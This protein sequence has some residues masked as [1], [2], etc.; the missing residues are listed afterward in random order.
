M[1]GS[2]HCKLTH[3]NIMERSFIFCVQLIVYS[4]IYMVGE[5]VRFLFTSCEESQLVNKNRTSELTMK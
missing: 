1:D 5:R 3:F 2:V 4:Y